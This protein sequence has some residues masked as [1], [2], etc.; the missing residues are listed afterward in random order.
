MLD[1]KIS[2]LATLAIQ[3]LPLLFYAY[4]SNRLAA[5]AA[6]LIPLTNRS[7]ADRRRSATAEKGTRK[8]R[9]RGRAPLVDLSNG[10]TRSY[11]PTTY[12]VEFQTE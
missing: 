5:A 1:N 3:P 12:E 11:R 7:T 2:K 4:I 9:S 6:P 10:R 8:G